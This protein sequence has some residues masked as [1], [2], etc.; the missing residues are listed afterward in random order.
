MRVIKRDGKIV[1]FDKSRIFNAVNLANIATGNNLNQETIKLVTDRVVAT[2]NN[3]YGKKDKIEIERI[4]DIVV[5]TLIEMNLKDI[6]KEYIE[7]RYKR[8]RT[9]EA[10]S[11]L[12]QVIRD[13]TIKDSK[14]L[15]LKRENANIDG[16]SSMG[17]MLR[18]GSEVAKTFTHLYLLRPEI[19]KAH[20]EGLIH[21]HDL[22]FYDKGT[23]NCLQI[24]LTK[25]FK[26]GFC[27]GH[28]SLRE[29]S[30]ISTAAS[31]AAIAI[32]SN[33]NDMFKLH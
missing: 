3:T 1:S 28:G 6:S 4:Q 15:D 11:N 33:Q 30:N 7:Y 9:R 14:D 26:N 27:T 5:D 20:R 8:D 16:N 23:C 13:L 18:E 25:L 21:I 22:D 17:I 2:L 29:P 19:S 32:Q 31:L 12:L 10:N 24:D